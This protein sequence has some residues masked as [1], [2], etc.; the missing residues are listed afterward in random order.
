MVARDIALARLTGG[1][2]H[3]A[4]VSTAGSIALLRAALA[5]GLNITAEVTPH[6][7]TM[8]DEWVAGRKTLAGQPVA[9]ERQTVYTFAA[10]AA[11]SAAELD[12]AA[13]L[14]PAPYTTVGEYPFP[15][16]TN[17]KVNPPLR[18]EADRQALVEAVADGTI[19]AIATDHAPHTVVDKQEEYGYAAF[20]ISGLETAFG[21]LMA[22]V[23]S[24]AID[25][26]TLIMRL[27]VGPARAFNLAGGSLSVDA[28]ADVVILAPDAEW[29]VDPSQFASKGQNT[30]LAGVTLRGKVLATIV[31]GEVA[32]GE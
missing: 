8:N 25:L 16:D 12:T 32:Y 18:A 30:P 10:S 13:L 22:L 31:G 26:A 27:T 3:L 24:G 4:H 11:P 6:H 7:L 9:E 1:R 15:Y 28:P 21:T 5:E 2:L 29:T 20:G 23:H 19:T 17:T 14:K